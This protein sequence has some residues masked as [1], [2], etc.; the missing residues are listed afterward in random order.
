MGDEWK[1]RNTY[2]FDAL[3][4]YLFNNIKANRDQEAYKIDKVRILN[5]RHMRWA[6]IN[7]DKLDKFIKENFKTDLHSIQSEIRKML[8]GE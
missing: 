4:F 6:E 3:C 1:F 5:P 8:N 2:L 7:I